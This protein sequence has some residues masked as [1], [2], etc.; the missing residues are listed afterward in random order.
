V[1]GE[2]DHV[3]GNNINDDRNKYSNV[4]N[5]EKISL[6]YY[7]GVMSNKLAGK[8]LSGMPACTFL[9]RRDE[10]NLNTYIISSV[11]Y[12]NSKA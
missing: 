2:K 7:A 4:K 3:D 11:G 10:I 8:Y 12:V 6:R 5:D 9:I 1:I